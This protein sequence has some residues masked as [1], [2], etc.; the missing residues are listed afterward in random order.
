MILRKISCL[1]SRALFSATKSLSKNICVVPFGFKLK[2]SA[3]EH[4]RF[5]TEHVGSWQSWLLFGL[6]VI[7]NSK[8]RSLCNLKFEMGKDECLAEQVRKYPVLYDKTR[9]EFKDRNVTTC[10]HGVN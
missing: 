4:V 6:F 1:C 5:G 9:K 2:T 3:Q 10:T 8:K 7:G